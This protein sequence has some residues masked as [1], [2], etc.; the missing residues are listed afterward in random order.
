MAIK[1][2]VV[3]EERARETG[4]IDEKKKVGRVKRQMG[5]NME[6]S[7][8]DMEWRNEGYGRGELTPEWCEIIGR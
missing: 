8:G 4:K 6:D 5:R 7:V 3:W 2:L 1:G